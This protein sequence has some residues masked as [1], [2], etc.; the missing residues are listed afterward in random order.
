MSAGLIMSLVLSVSGLMADESV[1][2]EEKT[3]AMGEK[4]ESRKQEAVAGIDKR[5]AALGELKTCLAAA[6]EGSAMRECQKK[7]QEAMMPLRMEREEKR[8]ERRME[9]LKRKQQD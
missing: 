1:K 4:F 8:H 7:H 5:I 2:P 6:Q 9:R 3:A